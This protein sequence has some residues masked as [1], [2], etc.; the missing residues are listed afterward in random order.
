MNTKSKQQH[1]ATHPREQLP[2][3]LDET[4]LKAAEGE[5]EI[6]FLRRSHHKSV[7]LS[8]NFTQNIPCPYFHNKIIFYWLCI[9]CEWSREMCLIGL[10]IFLESLVCAINAIKPCPHRACWVLVKQIFNTH[11]HTFIW[12]L[13]TVLRTIKKS[14]IKRNRAIE[15]KS[16]SQ[17]CDM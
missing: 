5:S 2:P 14:R 7:C 10:Y 1:N 12:L 11:T 15:F 3:I 13:H 8:L 9:E 4:E 16:A 17:G 6:R